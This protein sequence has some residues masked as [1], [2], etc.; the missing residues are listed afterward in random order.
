[1]YGGTR[2]SMKLHISNRLLRIPWLLS[3]WLK[4]VP[5]RTPANLRLAAFELSISQLSHYVYLHVYPTSPPSLSIVSR[6]EPKWPPD[7]LFR[8][9]H[10][11]ASRV[12]RR[13]IPARKAYYSPRE[14]RRVSQN[15]GRGVFLGS[16]D[17]T[18]AKLV[19]YDTTIVASVPVRDLTMLPRAPRIP[20]REEL[21]V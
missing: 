8:H 7:C 15:V 10:M 4:V 20:F 19:Y 14:L 12:N 16:V 17:A 2:L 5:Q 18:S 9:H 13:S 6:H 3:R 11:R 21:A 1:M